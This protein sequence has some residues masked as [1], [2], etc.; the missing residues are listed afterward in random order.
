MTFDPKSLEGLGYIAPGTTPVLVRNIIR[1]G[2]S[3]KR[4][5]FNAHRGPG[6]ETITCSDC[7]ATF[8]WHIQGATH[9]AETG[10][11]VVRRLVETFVGYC[12]DDE[13]GFRRIGGVMA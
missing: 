3:G 2:E 9:A 7:G 6:R 10:H 8:L 12:T 13:I 1:Q 4:F 11:C 5:P